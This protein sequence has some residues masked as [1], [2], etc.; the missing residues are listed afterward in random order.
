MRKSQ[1][2]IAIPATDASEA[3]VIDSAVITAIARN[4]ARPT[5]AYHVTG[6]VC[7]FI[8]RITAIEAGALREAV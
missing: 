3:R 2:R 7:S 1:L 5:G 4:F 8:A 6:A